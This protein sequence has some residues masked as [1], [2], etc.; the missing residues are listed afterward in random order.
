MKLKTS[1]KVSLLAAAAAVA[2][3]AQDPAKG[4]T[5]PAA[6]AT[7]AAPTAQAEPAAQ[8]T[9][10]QILETFGWFVG[11]RIGLSELKFSKEQTDI[12]VKGLLAAAEGKDAPYEL[13]K[14]GPEVDKFM[15]VKH[16]QHQTRMKQQ[17]QVEADKFMAEVKTKKGITVLP[18][19]LAY[20]IV[21]PGSGDYPKVGDVVKVHYTGT[22]VNG[23]KFD[24]S[25][26]GDPTEFTLA[27]DSVIA[28]WVEGV[29]KINKGGKIKLY[30]PP[31]LAYGESGPGAIPPNSALVFEVELIDIRAGAGAAAT[32]AAPAPKS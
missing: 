17:G 21:K 6:P 23:T 13:Q 9:E 19:G 3:Q 11:K 12:V 25:E 31:Q 1:F 24:S 2:A 16:Q 20:E 15:Q 7:P 8:F 27:N 32:P 30:I 4:A 22:L 5:T 26:G 28:G 18:S 14:V 29:Q 10:A